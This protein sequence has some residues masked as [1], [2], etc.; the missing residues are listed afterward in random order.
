MAMLCPA[1][2]V[3]GRRLWE[4]MHV[5]R[6]RERGRGWVLAGG[7]HCCCDVCQ[8]TDALQKPPMRRLSEAIPQ[9]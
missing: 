7:Y 4:H 8:G 1:M 6:L 9:H 2:M 3:N 5:R